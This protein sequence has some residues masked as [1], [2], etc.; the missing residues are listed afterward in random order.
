LKPT[1]PSC[2]S[3]GKPPSTPLYSWA[4][5][6]IL[7]LKGCPG[8]TCPLS[9]PGKGAV[10]HCHAA[11]VVLGWLYHCLV[12][13]AGRGRP[14][15]APA[16]TQRKLIYFFFP[17]TGIFM[18]A[19]PESSITGI[20]VSQPLLPLRHQTVTLIPQ[21][22]KAYR[23]VWNKLVSEWTLFTKSLPRLNLPFLNEYA[24][25]HA[26]QSQQQRSSSSQAISA[27]PGP[28]SAAL[29]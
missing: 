23:S 2:S 16:L 18:A 12:P 9:A 1:G 29:Q 22:V 25:S 28:S 11:Q 8:L 20:L 4:E 19:R 24:L 26:P 15:P 17:G 27:G 6:L 5:Y 3:S 13:A 7:A 21:Y 10:G 14:S